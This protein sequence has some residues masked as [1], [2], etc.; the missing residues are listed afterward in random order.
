MKLIA[1]ADKNW[2]IG[3]GGKMLAHLPADLRRFKEITKNK[4]VV[5]GRKTYESLPKKP[6]AD[7]VNIVLTRNKTYDRENV[8]T[9]NSIDELLTVLK[10]Y[11]DDDIYVIGGEEIYRALLDR[12]DTAFIT[13]IDAVFDADAFFPDLDKSSGWKETGRSEMMNDNNFMT[14]YIVYKNT[15]S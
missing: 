2:G 14:S 11:N 12:C 8:I 4:I 1:A 15:G 7:R 13:R 5:M 6:L 3:K 9:A 10:K